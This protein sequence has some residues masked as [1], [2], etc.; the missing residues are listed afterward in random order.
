MDEESA[1]VVLSEIVADLREELPPLIRLMDRDNLRQAAIDRHGV[2]GPSSFWKIAAWLK[3]EDGATAELERF[4]KDLGQHPGSP[5][6]DAVWSHA[7][8]LQHIVVV[9]TTINRVKRRLAPPEKAQPCDA[10]PGTGSKHCHQ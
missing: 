9:A 4:L 3:A 6:Y 1:T 2:L 10:V 5:V 8:D 7:L